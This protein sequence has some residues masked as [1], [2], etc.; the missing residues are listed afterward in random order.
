MGS[1]T[2]LTM[3]PS[4]AYGRPAGGGGGGAAA[5]ARRLNAA[6]RRRPALFAGLGLGL[7]IA[8]HMLFGLPGQGGGG[9]GDLI[10]DSA[11][12]GADDDLF[13][14]DGRL[15]GVAPVSTRSSST[16]SSSKTSKTTTTSSG[17]TIATGS[18][19]IGGGPRAG[20]GTAVGPPKPSPAPVYATPPPPRPQ[21]AAGA[22]PAGTASSSAD[23]GGGGGDGDWR[24]RAAAIPFTMVTGASSSYFGGLTNFVGSLHWWCP[25]CR[26]AVYDLGLTQQQ[27]DEVKSRWCGVA[28]VKLGET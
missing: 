3:S 18:S 23:G 20:A 28:L 25:R 27:R 4:K 19:G 22:P 1:Y 24:A 5:F 6:A 9:A 17:S 16:T 26:L 14:S 2:P 7:L 15:P 10:N 12:V 13:A 11:L 8:V 21:N